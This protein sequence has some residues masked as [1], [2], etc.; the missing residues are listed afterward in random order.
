M[1][2]LRAIPKFMPWYDL[3]KTNQVRGRS[4]D[5]YGFFREETCSSATK[6]LIL[7]SNNMINALLTCRLRRRC[8]RSVHIVHCPQGTS[9]RMYISLERDETKR[10]SQIGSSYEHLCHHSGH[11]EEHGSNC[12]TPDE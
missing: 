4:F 7:A 3:E 5:C 1:S 11:N 6:I 8:V 9:L 12:A 2:F 10:F